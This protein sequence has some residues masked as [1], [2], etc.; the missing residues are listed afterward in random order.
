MDRAASAE[1]MI[2]EQQAAWRGRSTEIMSDERN[3][4]DR[5]RDT[6]ALHVRLQHSESAKGY[7][8]LFEIEGRE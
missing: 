4:A 8:E 6:K 3:K 7:W 1:A 5:N 2:Q